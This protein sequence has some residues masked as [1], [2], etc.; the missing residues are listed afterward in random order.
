MPFRVIIKA[1]VATQV[2][3][4]PQD[5]FRYFRACV[6]EIEKDPFERTGL[7]VDVSDAPAISARTFLFEIVEQKSV[8]EERTPVFLSEFLAQYGVV[9]VVHDE[10][11]TAEI[12]HL[13]EMS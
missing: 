4:L 2:A 3:R 13:R 7:W 5:T 1:N 6:E 8:S 11:R 10:Q 9:Y 12:I